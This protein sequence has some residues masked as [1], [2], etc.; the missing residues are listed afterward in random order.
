MGS[1]P[2]QP[3][4][5]IVGPTASG[6]TALAIE[7]AKQFDG[8]IICADS[9]TVYKG[10]DIGTAKP[11]VPERQGIPHYLLDMVRP[12]EV[13]TVADFKRLADTAIASIH[14]KGK[15]P[16][17]VGGSGLYI[18]AV[19]FNYTFRPVNAEIRSQFE[20]ADVE[21]LQQ[22]LQDR[23]I[24]LPE[25]SRNKRYLLRSLEAGQESPRT[26]TIRPNTLILGID[27]DQ[28]VLDQRIAQRIDH[29]LDNGL[30]DE[31][32]TLASQYDSELPAMQAPAYKSFLP[33][34]QGSISVEQAKQDFAM[35]DRR[36][37]KKQRTWFKR[38]NRIQW[39]QE[40]GRAVDLVTTL[41]NN[42]P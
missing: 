19:L 26:T 33:Y 27:V 39:I 1:H 35:Y 11:T 20:D 6:K 2:N 36:L 34:L 42:N 23:G 9:R 12:D 38:N 31:V 28:V 40:Q 41:L 7:L 8:E 16:I 3:L 24:P 29:M 4:I 5:V 13:F 21:V 18:D 30:L 17:V 15:L 22:E 10:M 25:N 32:R 14:A 37:A